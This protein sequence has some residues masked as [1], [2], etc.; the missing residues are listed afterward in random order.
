MPENIKNK[1]SEM[2]DIYSDGDEKGESREL[3]HDLHDLFLV[4]NTAVGWP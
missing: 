4:D 3:L 2:D 1:I